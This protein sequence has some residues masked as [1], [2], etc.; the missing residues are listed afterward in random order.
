M[1]AD[2]L[3]G[4]VRHPAAIAFAKKLLA[5]KRHKATLSDITRHEAALWLTL[6]FSGGSAW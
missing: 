1:R 3:L 6:N 4:S 5:A 2:G